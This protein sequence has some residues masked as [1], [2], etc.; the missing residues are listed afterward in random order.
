MRATASSIHR[1]RSCLYWARDDVEWGEDGD[2]DAAQRGTLFHSSMAAA[3]SGVIPTADGSEN[4][5]MVR[6]AL[7]WLAC[8]FPGA[9]TVGVEDAY[10]YDL[11][12][13]RVIRT[14]KNREYG[15]LA[16]QEVGG[17][18]DLVQFCTDAPFAGLDSQ[19]PEPSIPELQV[20]DWKTGS[21]HN[22]QRA[23]ENDQMLT[24]ALLVVR[25]LGN[26]DRDVRV[27]LDFVSVDGVESDEAIVTQ[28]DLDAHEAWLR[29]VAKRIPT[30][31]PA[32][33]SHCKW[34]PAQGSCPATR[35]AAELVV[36][37]TPARR[38][39]PLV[40]NAGDFEGVEHAAWQYETV[41][42]AE[43]M[44]SRMKEALTSFADASGGIPLPNG[45]TY[46]RSVTS[47]ESVNLAAPGAIA[48]LIEVFGEDFSGAVEMKTSKTAIT[49]AA[50]RVAAR[51]KRKISHV[52]ADV[53]SR[54]RHVGAIDKK[55]SL[56]YGEVAA[57]GDPHGVPALPEGIA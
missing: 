19:I 49:S 36:A 54:L 14:A 28:W 37:E 9:D 6:A 33:G 2:S 8:E 35:E 22:T 3:L 10:V 11:S 44:I 53:L 40:T 43:A 42:A 25:H 39:L 12:L 45:K 38:R 51:D 32:T 15:H 52:E 47:R 57:K 13:G 56:T 41:R 18:V 26:W 48:A 50:R 55:T 23:A 20:R 27:A 17:T 24:L 4:T 7:E 31:A 29:D 5:R 1:L 30:S 34:C 21:P 46:M 16:P